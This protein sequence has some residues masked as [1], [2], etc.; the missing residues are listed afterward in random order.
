ME[1]DFLGNKFDVKLSRHV[2]KSRGARCRSRVCDDGVTIL[3][4]PHVP[5]EDRLGVV[6]MAITRALRPPALAL[7]LIALPLERISA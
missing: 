3:I 5:K 4:S 1:V 2:L 7:P 6:V